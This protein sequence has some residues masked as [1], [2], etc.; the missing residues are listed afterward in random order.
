[1]SQAVSLILHAFWLG[2]AQLCQ[3]ADVMHRTPGHGLA[4]ALAGSLVRQ[5][6]RMAPATAPKPAGCSHGAQRRQPQAAAVELQ[7][8]WILRSTV[9]S[10]IGCTSPFV[11]SLMSS[12]KEPQPPLPPPPAS[13]MPMLDSA[14]GSLNAASMMTAKVR[15]SAHAPA[16]H[17]SYRGNWLTFL[18]R[19]AQ[20]GTFGIM[21]GVSANENVQAAFAGQHRGMI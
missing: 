12:S 10:L 16:Y 17:A 20:A 1:M 18:G 8:S 19:A 11:A 13:S 6:S 2:S 21:N 9:V 5:S 3:V 15:C 4:A 7:S 14:V